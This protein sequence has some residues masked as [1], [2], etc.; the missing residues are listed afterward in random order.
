MQYDL[1]KMNGYNYTKYDSYGFSTNRVSLK[2][3]MMNKI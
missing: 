2:G 3:A 1:S